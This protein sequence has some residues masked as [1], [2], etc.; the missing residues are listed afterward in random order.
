MATLR[1][2]A[3]RFV[4]AGVTHA[5]RETTRLG[6]AIETFARS[7]GRAIGTFSAG[8]GRH[9]ASVTKA[10]AKISFKGMLVGGKLAFAGLGAAALGA[11]A[12]FGVISAK[13]KSVTDEITDYLRK[14]ETLSKTTGE[15]VSDIAALN[16]TADLNGG[17]ADELLPTLGTI[18][19]S[20][21]EIRRS[22]ED[23]DAAYAKTGTW[24]KR[25]L[26]AAIR[27]GDSNA[28]SGII[29]SAVA[30]REGSM[31]GIQDRQAG[32]YADIQ[33]TARGGK[34]WRRA[35]NAGMSERD[36]S[37][38]MSR[39][40][41]AL[42]AEYKSLEE[43]KKRVEDGM[44]PAGEALRRLE[45]VGLDMDKALK[46]GV[47]TLYALADAL[48]RIPDSNE[49]LG[50]A[51]Q[52]FGEDAGAKNL[53]LLQ[54]GRA[55]IERNRREM[56]RYGAMPTEED[57]ARGADLKKSEGRRSMALQGVKL[58]LHRG[59][60]PLMEE[61]NDQLAEWLV[62]NR[63][64]ITSMVQETF[65]AART[66]F[67]DVLKFL[68]G[69]TDYES[70]FFAKA[71]A[72]FKFARKVVVAITVIAAEAMTEVGEILSGAD[73]NWAWLNHVRDAFL[74]IKALAIDA[75]AVITG[76]GQAVNFEWLNTART[77]FD[78]FMKHLKAAW[79]MFRKVLDGI[80]AAVKPV[81]SFFNTDL[82]TAVLF[83]AMLKFSGILKAIALAGSGLL[84]IFRPAL[85]GIGAAAMAAA[86]KIG[87]IGAAFTAAYVGSQMVAG[88][89]A[90][91]FV[92]REEA[93]QDK[94]AELMKVR[95]QAYIEDKY[96][97]IKDP[98]QRRR[99]QKGLGFNYYSGKLASEQRD[100]DIALFN[101]GQV[102]VIGRDYDKPMTD[103]EKARAGAM[104]R[105]LQE[106]QG[107]G[108][109]FNVN[110][111]LGGKTTSMFGAG[112]PAVVAELERLE[113][114][115]GNY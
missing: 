32:I 41:L 94:I 35:I 102:R 45:E 103:E 89:L 40:R 25:G 11:A 9:I 6:R 115:G 36:V 61:A 55:A 58:E 79:E 7:A 14:I 46:G 33:K 18:A 82:T 111:S 100:E 114:A 62:R 68:E 52:L 84:G 65:L 93:I 26:I 104:H 8:A 39:R 1:A 88:F 72:V 108:K 49:K 29:A 51:Q 106:R 47:D 75:F 64:A 44:G 30:A 56:E 96:S 28:A 17:D 48:D 73:S 80:H 70:A 24:T 85:T 67:Y 20:F 107:A 50:I 43:A 42:V 2:I 12:K 90:D 19:D 3:T 60:A 27:T 15:S 98:E 86:T 21:G 16:Y 54:G 31:T 57:T 53:A 10:L 109:I 22:I 4:I 37:A 63:T 69:N 87:L 38:Y 5:V 97:K 78:D 81:L 66:I 99:F 101:S 95:D 77:M 13:A 92:K 34:D 76:S 113:R 112:D 91:Q 59:I 74:W 83:V 23:A 71:A 110:L 105:A